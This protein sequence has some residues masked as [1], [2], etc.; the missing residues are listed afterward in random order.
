MKKSII[1]TTVISNSEFVSLI[2]IAKLGRV[3]HWLSV[4]CEKKNPESRD[5]FLSRE[6]QK[7]VLSMLSEEVY[8]ME[9]TRG[10][11]IC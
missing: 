5:A 2:K 7:V 9:K 8:E 11:E 6:S 10:R 4:I 1:K 3:A